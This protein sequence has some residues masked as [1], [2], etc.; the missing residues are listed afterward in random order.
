[1]KKVIALFLLPLFIYSQGLEFINPEDTEL[2]DRFDANAF[3]YSENIPSS[4][5]LKKYVPPVRDQGSTSTCVGFSMGYYAISTMH[6]IYFD[7]TSTIEKFIHAFDPLYAYTLNDD[8]CSQGLNMVQA[9]KMFSNYGAKKSVFYPIDI[10]C[11]NPISDDKLDEISSLTKPYELEGF[12]FIQTYNRNFIE[13]VK[14]SIFNK[15]PVIIGA[16]ITESLY[17]VSKSPSSGNT[18]WKPKSDEENEGG[19]AMC[20]IGFNDNIDGGSFHVVNSWGTDWGDNGYFWISYSDF[21]SYVNEAY[22]I[23]PYNLNFDDKTP[24]TLNFNDSYYY[25][26]GENKSWSYEGQINTENEFNGFGIIGITRNDGSV[27]HSV[28]RFE[29]DNRE[30]IHL[31]VD[32]DGLFSVNFVNDEAEEIK[33]LGFSDQDSELKSQ[34]KKIGYDIEI[35]KMSR[36]EIENFKFGDSVGKWKIRKKNKVKN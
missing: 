22:V 3:G 28:G 32:S 7:R 35:K 21:Y 25:F 31:L 11:E 14:K 36:L 20:V 16:N 15:S 9:F 23:K 29:K 19:H 26:E 13:N 5:S 2:L 34:M 33:E 30:G 24:N 1:M 4:Y 6:N 8:D 17:D 10:D 27:Y 18:I 12:E